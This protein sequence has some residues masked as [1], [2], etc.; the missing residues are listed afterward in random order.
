MTRLPVSSSSMAIQRQTR[1]LSFAERAAKVRTQ[2]VSYLAARA[3]LPAPFVGKVTS[4]G[5]KAHQADTAKSQYGFSGEGIR[6]GVMSDSFNYL[7]GLAAD[8]AGG[9]LPG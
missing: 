4:Q 5:D 6:I 1:H 2:L 7:G 3:G 8:I 9:D